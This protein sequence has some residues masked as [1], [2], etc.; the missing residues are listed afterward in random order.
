MSQ[1]LLGAALPQSLSKKKF[2]RLAGFFGFFSGMSADFD[3]FIRSSADPLLFLEFHRQFTHSLIFVP[4][5]GLI[6]SVF[7]FLI[8]GRKRNCSF[9][10][11]FYFCTL[12]YGTHALLDACTSYGT[13]LFWPF[14]YERVSW[15]NISIIDPLFTIPILILLLIAFWKKKI[16]FSRIAFVW[17][18][19][20]LALGIVFRN[21]AI[22]MGREIAVQRAHSPI[23][24]EAKPSIGNIFLWKTIYEHSGRY[25]IDAV[26]TGPYPKIFLGESIAKLNL[27][28]NFAWVKAGSQQS[29][30]IERFR[31]FSNGYLAQDEDNKDRII[32]VRYSMVPN[33]IEPLWFIELSK[34]TDFNTHVSYK[35]NR[36][37]SRSTIRLFLKML[38]S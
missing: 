1:G 20:Y 25:Y 21:A 36:S 26:R 16:K 33:R 4:L 18:I 23:L 28:S 13:L 14:S 6:C 27:K 8:L 29:K 11:T 34:N 3:I 30:D 5:G 15:N 37:L 22:E 31:W 24:V 38:W 17:A 32:D 9:R 19:T 2:I 12:G 35:R 7:F 10:L